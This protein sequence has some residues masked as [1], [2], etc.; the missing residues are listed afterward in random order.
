MNFVGS[1][2]ACLEKSFTTRQSFKKVLE[3]TDKLIE[4]CLKYLDYLELN[5]TAVSEYQSL[6]RPNPKETVVELPHLHGLLDGKHKNRREL[7][8]IEG[9]EENLHLRFLRPCLFR[10]NISER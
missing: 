7:L 5:L 2:T 6:E 10:R 4:S 3:L 1:V 8:A 9:V